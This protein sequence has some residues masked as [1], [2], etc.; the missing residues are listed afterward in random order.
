MLAF[1]LLQLARL[2]RRFAKMAENAEK[3][4]PDA[5]NAAAN[6]LAAEMKRLAPKR[7]GALTDSI[8]VT[9]GG[10]STP[11]NGSGEA[12]VVPDGRVAV[13]CGN[14]ATVY[15][16]EI[17]FGTSKDHAEPFFVPAIRSQKPKMVAAVRD[18]V[19]AAVRDG[20]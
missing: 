19:A 18:A 4:A 9:P 15:A 3:A 1:N 16:K 20:A 13:T 6:D 7:T 5:L 10:Q 11:E 14:A 8:V 12:H 2:K 17:E